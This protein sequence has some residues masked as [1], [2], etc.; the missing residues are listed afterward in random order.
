MAKSATASVEAAAL[1]NI[2]MDKMIQD[3]RWYLLQYTIPDGKSVSALLA[4]G[5]DLKVPFSAKISTSAQSK[6]AP[7][8]ANILHD[9]GIN[10]TISL[11]HLNWNVA[12]ESLG[13][14]DTYDYMPGGSWAITGLDGTPYTAFQGSGELGDGL[15]AQYQCLR[16]GGRFRSDGLFATKRSH[17]PVWK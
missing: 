11:S 13:M 8:E 15:G 17:N 3:S 16:P 7:A 14:I 4:R 12:G 1:G 2:R 6:P 10:G 5:S 9:F